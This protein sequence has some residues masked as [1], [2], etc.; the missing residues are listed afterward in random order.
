MTKYFLLYF[1]PIR[2]IYYLLIVKLIFI[3]D[4]FLH[5][6]DSFFYSKK[7][8]LKFR[9]NKMLF[10]IS[11]INQEILFNSFTCSIYLILKQ[12]NQRFY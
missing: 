7:L 4:F 11:K 8:L 9:I 1:F 3:F 12:I 5:F 10:K 6:V 2:Y